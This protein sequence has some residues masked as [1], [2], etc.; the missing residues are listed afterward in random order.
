MII[1]LFWF[2]CDCDSFFLHELDR[3]TYSRLAKKKRKDQKLNKKNRFFD[4]IPTFIECRTKRM[5]K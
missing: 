5:L 2:Y 1:N 4:Y 3:I